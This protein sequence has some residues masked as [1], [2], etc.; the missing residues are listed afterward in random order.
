M[1]ALQSIQAHL[2]TLNL[3]EGDYLVLVN[4]LKTVYKA[5]PAQEKTDDDPIAY[6][7]PFGTP[8]V[9]PDLNDIYATARDAGL[10]TT[11][12][13]LRF[14]FHPYEKKIVRLFHTFATNIDGTWEQLDA[15]L[16]TVVSEFP[17]PEN[18]YFWLVKYVIN[19]L[20]EEWRDDLIYSKVCRQAIIH[21][22]AIN[23]MGA[24]ARVIQGTNNHGSFN[25]DTF[26]NSRYMFSAFSSGVALSERHNYHK[27]QIDI[28]TLA[29][30]FTGEQNRVANEQLTLYTKMIRL[31][32]HARSANQLYMFVAIRALLNGTVTA[33]MIARMAG[34]N[35]CSTWRMRV[36]GITARTRKRNREYE[37]DFARVLYVDRLNDGG[38][39]A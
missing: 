2:E 7:I 9:S 34:R 25:Q 15:D 6:N 39:E 36:S 16:A 18:A 14:A 1:D 23:W 11:T 20:T 19:N 10:F 37:C 27:L 32:G 8:T 21:M 30:P 4:H 12:D 33:P 17:R 13:W 28:N 29:T 3:A 35:G 31:G 38:G 5:L 24:T 26:F 22:N